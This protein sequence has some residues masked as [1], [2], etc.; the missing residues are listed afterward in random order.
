VRF[1]A[2]IIL[3][4]AVNVQAQKEVSPGLFE[5]GKVR[6]DKQKRTIAFP[7]AVNMNQGIVEYFLVS[8]K[9]KVHESVLRTDVEPYQIQVAMLL[10][11][12]R[13]A[14]TNSF[15]TNQ[16]PRGDAVIIEVSWKGLLS[17]KRVLAEEMVIDRA[18][19]APMTKGPWIYNGSFQFENLFVAQETGSMISTIADPEAL[20]NNPRERRDDDDNWIVN[21]KVVPDAETRVMVTIRVPRTSP[22]EGGAS[23]TSSR[24]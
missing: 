20:I 7:A 12:G 14:Q 4:L 17:T 5:L 10:L 11:G 18:R 13:G 21:S 2:A 15:G 3:A 23:G 6:V 9:G 24:R 22:A 16:M 8:T 1:I 19:N